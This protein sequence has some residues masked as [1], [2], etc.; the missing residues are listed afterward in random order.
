[1]EYVSKHYSKQEGEC[2]G[3]I[4]CWIDLFVKRDTISINDLLER[5]HEII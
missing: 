2:H 1:M 3:C 4:Y 5:P